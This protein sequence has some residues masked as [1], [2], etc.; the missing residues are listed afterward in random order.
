MLSVVP[1]QYSSVTDRQ[2]Y[3][4]HRIP[5]ALPLRRAVKVSWHAATE[6]SVADLLKFLRL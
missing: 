5:R 2:K 6:K 4:A 3:V 1:I